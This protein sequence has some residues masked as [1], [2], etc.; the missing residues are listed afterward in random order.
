MTTG[1]LTDYR[2]Y[3]I[4]TRQ[5]VYTEGVKE[6]LNEESDKAFLALSLLLSS[7]LGRVKYKTLDQ[8]SRAEI[9]KLVSSISEIQD[10]FYSKYIDSLMAKLK[11]FMGVDLEVSRKVYAVAHKEIA[12][13]DDEE[14]I[15]IPSDNESIKY[16][17]KENKGSGITAAL[18]ISAVTGADDRLWSAIRSAPLPATGSN[19]IQFVKS[20]AESAQA[21]VENGVRKAWANGDEVSQA[22][23]DIT[24]IEAVQGTSSTMQRIAVQATAVQATAVQHVSAITTSAVQSAL[25]EWYTWHSVIDSRTT[26]ICQSRNLK[27]Y[28]YGEGPLP[29]AHVRCRSHIAP[30]TKS[31][32]V[33]AESFFDWIKRQPDMIQDDILGKSGGEALRSGKTKPEDL[34]KYSGKNALTLEEFRKKTNYILIKDGE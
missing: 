18:G 31:D 7:V 3:D 24:S 17:I 32:T 6:E 20:F 27:R 34:Q 4:S 33:K 21:S 1:S 16:I 22:I 15:K 23:T 5:Q 30:S 8:L 12:A 9:N 11:D 29:P 10:R 19:I 13:P 25:F 26:E 28:K 14:Q 2:L